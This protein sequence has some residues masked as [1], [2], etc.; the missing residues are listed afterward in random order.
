MESSLERFTKVAASLDEAKI[1]YDTPANNL[2]AAGG[3]AALSVP[4]SARNIK[5]SKL[6]LPMMAGALG[7]RGLVKD[8]LIAK[9]NIDNYRTAQNGGF[10]NG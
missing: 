1:K 2:L 7:Y 9:T 5:G 10:A 3:L 8:R 4:M 6:A